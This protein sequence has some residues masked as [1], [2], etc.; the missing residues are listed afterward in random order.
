MYRLMI[1]SSS[2]PS[3]RA[4]III[5][6][7]A[8]FS[9][10]PCR[11]HFKTSSRWDEKCADVLR[12]TQV[13]VT[14]KIFSNCC[15]ASVASEQ[16][17]DQNLRRIYKRKYEFS[18]SSLFTRMHCIYIVTRVHCATAEEHE[19]VFACRAVD[20]SKHFCSDLPGRVLDQHCQH[21]TDIKFVPVQNL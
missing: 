21:S 3:S 16:Q 17:H 15:G 1:L 10:G 19:N 7:R 8:P 14:S 18:N 6:P 4:M 9:F 12:V 11:R 5:V 13:M 20:S 2:Q